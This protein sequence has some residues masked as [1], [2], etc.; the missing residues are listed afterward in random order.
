M[1]LLMVTDPAKFE[2]ELE[3]RADCQNVKKDR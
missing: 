3:L 2:N 1:L